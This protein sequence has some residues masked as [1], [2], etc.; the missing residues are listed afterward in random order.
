MCYLNSAKHFTVRRNLLTLIASLRSHRFPS[1]FVTYLTLWI[2]V[3]FKIHLKSSLNSSLETWM[4]AFDLYRK[5]RNNKSFYTNTD[6]NMTENGSVEDKRV[7]IPSEDAREKFP[8]FLV[9]TYAAVIVQKEGFIAHTQ[10]TARRINSPSLRD[11]Y[12][13]ASKPID[14]GRLQCHLCRNC[15]LARH[16]ASFYQWWNSALCW[17]PVF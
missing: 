8:Q 1:A 17:G 12:N 3:N 2:I 5:A 13:T 14:K 16:W 10:N 11:G 9:L 7:S 15:T 4:V 6:Y